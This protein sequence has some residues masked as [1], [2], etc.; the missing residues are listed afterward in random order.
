MAPAFS[1]LNES[2]YT[3]TNSVDSAGTTSVLEEVHRE[4]SEKERRKRNVVVSGL[5][6][7]DGIDDINTFL[8]LCEECLPVRPAGHS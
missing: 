5:K 3:A 8:D 6:E 4:F 7:S 1:G 2:T